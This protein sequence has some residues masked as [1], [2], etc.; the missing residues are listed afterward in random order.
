MYPLAQGRRPAP[1]LDS[2]SHIGIK[3]LTEDVANA[4]S[5]GSL[6][7]GDMLPGLSVSL[8]VINVTWSLFLWSEPGSSPWV[9][10]SQHTGFHIHPVYSQISS[11]G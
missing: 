1:W 10:I 7:R 2:V 8:R 3:E 4:G 11:H 6:P 9:F 5:L